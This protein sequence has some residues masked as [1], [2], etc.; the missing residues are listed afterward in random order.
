MVESLGEVVVADP[1]GVAI[2]Q[3]V[4]EPFGTEHP[5]ELRIIAAYK[6]MSPYPDGAGHI[7]VPHALV[8]QVNAFLNFHR[9]CLFPTDVTGAT[10]RVK[11]RYRQ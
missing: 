5:T 6:P 10:G 4:L 2:R 11:K 1:L 7:H 3:E 9:P 8:P